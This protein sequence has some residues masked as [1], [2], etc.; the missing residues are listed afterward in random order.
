MSDGSL[1]QLR[2]QWNST[3]QVFVQHYGDYLVGRGYADTSVRESIR[4]VEHFRRW[5]GRRSLSPAAVQ[6]FLRQHVPICRCEPP[7]IRYQ[8]R[9]S[10]ALNRLLAVIQPRVKMRQFEFPRGFAGELLQR[11][12]ERLT[13]VRGLVAG[14][15]RNRLR[16]ALNMLTRL[17]AKRA[18]HL[19]AWTPRRVE[20]YVATEVRRQ[21]P[22]TTCS[23]TTATRCFLRFL[24]QEGLIQRDLSVVVPTFARWRLASL[25]KTLRA[26]ELAKLLNGPDINT[27]I[28]LRDRAILLCL[29]EL[30]LRAAE[31]AGLELDAIDL[32]SGV[33][34]VNRGKRGGL[35]MLPI[36][37][38]LATALK[39]YIR[40]GRPKCTSQT[41][42]VA[43]WPPDIGKPI[44]PVTVSVLVKRW[45]AR[46]GLRKEVSAAHVLRHTIASRMLGAG[47]SLRQIAD[48]LGHRSIDTTTIYAKVD[49]NAL[50]QVG[51]PWP[52]T[53][54]V[55]P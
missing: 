27:P 41:V 45:S 11:Y 24:L 18:S 25:P 50:S 7:Q 43:H 44:R 8:K 39:A 16:S 23:V 10:L 9:N 52:K 38:R 42:F 35:A 20:G 17:R 55:K 4:I 21:Q 48:V 19:A 5:L 29:S 3:D 22:S 36:P 14:T 51:L 47:A 1:C 32:V 53:K 13:S 15:V 31:V 37:R 40:H 2:S 30:G 46:A 54:G 33:L 26:D 34:Q 28:G 49:L 6:Q 12:Q